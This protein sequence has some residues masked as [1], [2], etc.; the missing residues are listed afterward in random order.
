MEMVE[1]YH[2]FQKKI[3]YLYFVCNFEDFFS[4]N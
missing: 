1:R 4:V 2:Y 3:K